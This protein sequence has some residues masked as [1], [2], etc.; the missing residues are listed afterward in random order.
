[1]MVK[2]TNID[3][4]GVIAYPKGSIKTNDMWLT[5]TNNIKPCTGLLKP[6]YV[7]DLCEYEIVGWA[8]KN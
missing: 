7:N 2:K 5:R 6:T 3:T 1:M 8:R 4:L